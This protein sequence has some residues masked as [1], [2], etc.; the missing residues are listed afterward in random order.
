MWYLKKSYPVI[1]VNIL[2][3]I[4]TFLHF[5]VEDNKAHLIVGV[6][7]TIV[8]FITLFILIKMYV[9]ERRERETKKKEITILLNELKNSLESLVYTKKYSS[10]L[11]EELFKA[12]AKQF[13]EK[14]KKERKV[15]EKED[16]A[17]QDEVSESTYSSAETDLE[18]K[19]DK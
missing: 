2:L 3:F 10:T 16:V 13:L 11:D 15:E 6:L 1:L 18:E 8:S 7:M 12:F 5:T 17:D 9:E 19:T 4:S 14:N